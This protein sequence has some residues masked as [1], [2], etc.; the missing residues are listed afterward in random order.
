MKNNI[1]ELIKKTFKNAK[2]V[3]EKIDNQKKS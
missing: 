2:D 3:K 1:Q